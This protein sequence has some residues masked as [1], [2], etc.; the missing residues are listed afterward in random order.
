MLGEIGISVFG[1]FRELF[2]RIELGGNLK[3]FIIVFIGD[4]ICLRVCC[5][6]VIK[7][8]FEIG[9]VII[10]GIDVDGMEVIG[11]FGGRGVFCICIGNFIVFFDWF[12]I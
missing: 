12:G 7:F 10:G 2:R 1:L 9:N 11:V 8:V 5:L 6:E 3:R 4:F